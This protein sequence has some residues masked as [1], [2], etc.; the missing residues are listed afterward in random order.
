MR[1]RHRRPG[2][3]SGLQSSARRRRDP[4]VGGR[5][6]YHAP[7]HTQPATEGAGNELSRDPQ[8]PAPGTRMPPPERHPNATAV[9]RRTPRVRGHIRIQ[10]GLPSLDRDPAG[11][12][13]YPGMARLRGNPA[14]RS[15]T[16]SINPHLPIATARRGIQVVLGMAESSLG[17]GPGSNNSFDRLAPRHT[18]ASVGKCQR[19]A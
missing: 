14:R 4:G 12:L 15:R 3:P 17:T 9:D 18:A 11:G 19:L 13:A 2:P 6:L 16:G 7:A 5:G 8:H 10:P 1:S